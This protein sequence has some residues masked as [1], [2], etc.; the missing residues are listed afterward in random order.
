MS[1]LFHN[2]SIPLLIACQTRSDLVRR[3]LFIPT[4]CTCRAVVKDAT[5]KAR[6]G[7]T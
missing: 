7:L 5:T 2:G 1:F 6:K 4:K 3:T